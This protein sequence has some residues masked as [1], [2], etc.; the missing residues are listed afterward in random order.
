MS[1]AHD[2][3]GPATGGLM[4][5]MIG[6]A[7]PLRAIGQALETLNLTAFELEPTGDDYYVRGVL[8]A[9][10]PA[11]SQ[12]GPTSERLSTVWGRLP[13][14]EQENANSETTAAA[15]MLTPIEL[16]YTPKDVDRLEQEGQARRT[17]VHRIP[18]TATLSQ[19]LRCIGAYVN[20]KPARLVKIIR[21][22]DAVTIEYETS[23]GTQMRETFGTSALYDLWVRMYMQRAERETN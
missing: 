13:P 6:Y 7:Q 16:Q 21:E 14:R 15:P 9:T 22:L 4:S 10:H 5:G 20:Q 3:I 12:D 17:D 2:E 11:L 19:V 1:L 8:A 23:L 18:D